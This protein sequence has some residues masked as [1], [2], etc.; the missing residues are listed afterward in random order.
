M[1]LLRVALNLFGNLETHRRRALGLRLR[2]RHLI[3]LLRSPCA[4]LDPLE[5]EAAVL[6]G[7]AVAESSAAVAETVECTETATVGESIATEGVIADSNT[8]RKGVLSQLR[9]LRVAVSVFS[10][11]EHKN[12]RRLAQMCNMLPP[13]TRWDSEWP[14]VIFSRELECGSISLS[15]IF[16]EYVKHI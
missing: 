12:F 6:S 14:T 9:E 8:S 10:P 1:P 4:T 16:C 5:A 2:R 3:L 7:E 11:C 13:D 15:Q